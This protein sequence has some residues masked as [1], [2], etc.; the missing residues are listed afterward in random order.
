[1][2]EFVI[3]VVVYCDNDDDDDDD[4]EPQGGDG[5]AVQGTV[6]I[7]ISRCYIE[8]YY[9]AF[10]FIVSI[11]IDLFVRCLNSIFSII[12]YVVIHLAYSELI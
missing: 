9:D 7:H 11:L 12:C 5:A 3:G 8:I 4:D 6:S 2:R 1:M 10:V